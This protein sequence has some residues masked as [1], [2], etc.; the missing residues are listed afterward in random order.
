LYK[1]AADSDG[2]VGIT[3][4]SSDCKA[5]KASKVSCQPERAIASLLVLI[6]ELAQPAAATLP[7][8]QGQH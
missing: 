3:L 6:T 7:F 4:C 2:A 5:S 1:D 8:T